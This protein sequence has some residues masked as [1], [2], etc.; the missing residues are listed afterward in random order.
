MGEAQV[1][2]QYRK[3]WRNDIVALCP[4]GDEEDK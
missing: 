3:R 2:V 4:N 1:I